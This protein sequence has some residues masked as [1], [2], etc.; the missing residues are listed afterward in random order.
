[1]GKNT[2]T[3]T[4]KI[5]F[6]D[7]IKTKL[8]AVMVLVM[9][10]PLIIAVAVSYVT[11]T[12]KAL[13]DAQDSMEWE[14]WY[15]E[16][17]FV[18]I[19]EKNVAIISSIAGNPT[20]INFVKGEGNI[21]YDAVQLTLQE[22]DAVLGDGENTSITD[23]TGM[24]IARGKGDF[25]S[26]ADREY[27]KSAISGQTF[28]SNITVSKTNG[29]RMVT[30]AVPIKD[31]DKI[32]GIVHRNYNLQNFHEMLANE[33]E[34]A[35]LVDRNGQVAAHSQ[36]EIGEGANDEEDRSYAEF[37]T[38]GKSDGFYFGDPGSGEEAYVAYVKEPQSNFI[39]VTVKDE[40][41]VLSAARR[42]AMMVVFVGMA[43]LVVAV[44]ISFLMAK[45]FIDPI[46]AVGG[47]LGAL[48]DGRFAQVEGFTKRKD[49]FG[50]ISRATNSVIGKLE[51]IVSNIKASAANVGESSDELSD[52]ANQISNTADDV[53]NAVQEIAS[54]ATQQ[55]DEIQQA[56]ENA[57]RIGD[58]VND[59]QTSSKELVELADRMKKTSEVSSKSLASLQKSTAEM[60]GKIDDISKTIEAT[61][62]A[63]N[64]IDE[65]VEGI[66]SIASQTN[67]L[68]LN[69]SIE[70]ARAGE[71]GRGFA[72]VAEEISKLADDSRQMADEIKLEMETLLNQSRAA[73]GAAKDVKQGNDSQQAALGE[74]L[75]A[76]NGMLEDIGSTVE[77]VKRISE[78]A[79]TC[80]ES[81]NVVID[82]MSALSAISEENAASSEETGASMEELSATVTT[83]AGA[84]NNLK[85]IADKLNEDMKFFKS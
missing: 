22:C 74:T 10:I 3:N 44:I 64:I 35:F 27:F 46:K 16:D 33:S 78:G 26:V 7:S 11:S 57:G 62:N 24:Q 4:A 41:A 39:I 38:A 53:S 81:K 82:N 18:T 1:M 73:V 58:A 9:A 19:M 66:T 40:D 20:I 6:K 80:D 5:S 42:A 84:A 31:G 72:V 17:R 15:I 65:K 51:D 56:N 36:Y 30:F 13:A 28:V 85:E 77:G 54:G 47:S 67:L 60:T 70:A 37:F 8:I 2:E 83:L 55:A 50:E 23:E 79:E 59:V 48:A 29:R 32:L 12:N 34:N 25:I 45:S 14:A 43:L 49:E 52:M 75:E 69:A 21:P 76:V 71:A 68:S 63:V 61:Q